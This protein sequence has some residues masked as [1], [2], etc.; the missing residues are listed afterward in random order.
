MPRH[1]YPT[2]ISGQFPVCIAV[3]VLQERS[4][5]SIWRASCLLGTTA[6]G[7]L[8][9]RRRRWAIPMPGRGACQYAGRMLEGSIK[10]SPT[11]IAAA[12]ADAVTAGFAGGGAAGPG[13]P[14]ASAV[15]C[16]ASSV[17]ITLANLALWLNASVV[18]PLAAPL[19]LIAALFV[20]NMSYG[21]VAEER[22]KRL[23]KKR[24]GQYVSPEVIEEM[25]AN[26]QLQTRWKAAARNMTVLFSD[27][28]NF[29]GI[30]EGME[31]KI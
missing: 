19:L 13:K 3:D 5:R 15:D 11:A 14:C 29:T 9:I 6:A 12:Q 20:L 17:L 8:T 27:I 1:G 31:P 25:I 26:P 2:R 30:S 28:R 24:F 7:L 18:L 16:T 21:F 10:K 4:T 22:T 23:Y